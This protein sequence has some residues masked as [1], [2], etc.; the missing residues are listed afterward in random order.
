MSLTGEPWRP[1][2]A[3]AGNTM[4]QSGVIPASQ[5]AA[6]LK[7]LVAPKAVQVTVA[8]AAAGAERSRIREQEAN[9]IRNAVIVELGF[10]IGLFSLGFSGG[11]CSEGGT[12]LV[13]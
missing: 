7:L 12:S 1:N 9:I 10:F 2:A 3:P 8:A 11:E 4:M 6:S 13:L 5:L